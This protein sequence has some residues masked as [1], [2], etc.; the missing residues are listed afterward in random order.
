MR[1]GSLLRNA[2]PFTE[3]SCAEPVKSTRGLLAEAGDAGAL[4]YPV[5]IVFSNEGRGVV[6]GH[7]PP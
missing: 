2:E 6:G 1:V 3:F 5:P 7:H 4:D